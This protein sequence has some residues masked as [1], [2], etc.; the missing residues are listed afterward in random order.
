M[1]VTAG[2]AGFYIASTVTVMLWRFNKNLIQTRKSEWAPYALEPLYFFLL[3]LT[4]GWF[5]LQINQTGYQSLDSSKFP[6]SSNRPIP[7][8]ENDQGGDKLAPLTDSEN[9]V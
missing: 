8:N 3:L 9:D 4:G 2:L 1:S 6:F 5:W 7:Q